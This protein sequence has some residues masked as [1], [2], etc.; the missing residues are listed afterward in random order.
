MQV[1]R[2]CRNV[3]LLML[4]VCGAAV[5]EPPKAVV[6]TLCRPTFE[7]KDQSLSAGTAFL[8]ETGVGTQSVELVTAH[9]Q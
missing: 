5:A 4:S 2:S 6:D 1:N 7:L 3:L 9:H 8:M